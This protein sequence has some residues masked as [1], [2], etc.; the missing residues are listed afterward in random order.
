MDHVKVLKRTWEILWRYRVLWVFGLILALTSAGGGGN[1]YASWGGDGGPDLSQGLAIA[2][3]PP[4]VVTALIAIALPLACLAIVLTVARFIFHY[5]AQ[6]A[7]IRMVDDYEETGEKR[8]VRQGFRLGWS[9]TTLRLFVIDLLTRLPG[10]L[11]IFL[12]FLLGVVL[13]GWI[14]WAREAAVAMVIGV[15]GAIGIGF[16]LIL[17]AIVVSLVVS[18]LRQFFWRVCALEEMGVI[19]SIRQGYAFV[20]QHLGDAVI[21]WLIM[22]GLEIGW[23]ITMIPVVLVLLVVAAI[24]GFL[25]ALLVGGLAKLAF[26]GAIPWLLA[27]VVGIPIFI[28]VMAGPLMFLG[29]LA[30]VFKSTVWTLTYRELRALGGLETAPGQSPVLDTPAV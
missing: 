7:L 29:A 14:L 24:F 25:P 1:Q 26:E 16:L 19:D 3:I 22:L 10:I 30:E 27:A 5:I 28:I 15:V 23:I 8:G 4:E 9:R 17:L 18:L 12:L 6:A 11:V 21:M 20:R 13:F 2:K